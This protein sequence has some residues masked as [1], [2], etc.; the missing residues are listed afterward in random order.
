M[1]G[2]FIV[3]RNLEWWFASKGVRKKLKAPRAKIFQNRKID[4]FKPVPHM[5]H[6]PVWRGFL[7]W[8]AVRFFQFLFKNEGLKLDKNRFLGICARMDSS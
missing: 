4:Q 6:F 5:G 2:K 8:K 7:G 1:C 3:Y